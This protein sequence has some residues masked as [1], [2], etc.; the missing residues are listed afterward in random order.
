MQNIEGLLVDVM[1]DDDT[2]DAELVDEGDPLQIR[3]GSDASSLSPTQR[4]R[5]RRM[6]VRDG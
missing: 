2:V 5:Q 1:D 3:Q 4:R 6:R